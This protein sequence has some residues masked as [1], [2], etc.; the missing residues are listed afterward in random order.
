MFNIRSENWRRSL[1]STLDTCFNRY[2]YLGLIRL[3]IYFKSGLWGG[4]E[5]GLKI[6]VYILFSWAFDQNSKNINVKEFEILWIMTFCIVKSCELWIMT[7][8]SLVK[9]FVIYLIVNF[10][11]SVKRTKDL[12]VFCLVNFWKFFRNFL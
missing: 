6:V 12:T 10:D 5:R 7:F 2:R 3:Q 4:G 1:G 11:N 8:C 9:D